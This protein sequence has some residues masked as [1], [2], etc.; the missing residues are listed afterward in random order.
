MATFCVFH[1]DP[2]ILQKSRPENPGNK[3]PENAGA[4]MRPKSGVMDTDERLS[5]RGVINGYR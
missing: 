5:K 1:C 4:W 2:G 3:I